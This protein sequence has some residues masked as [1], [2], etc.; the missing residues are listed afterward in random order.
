MDTNWDEIEET[1]EL[2]RSSQ[3]RDERQRTSKSQK[4]CSA[5]AGDLKGFHAKTLLV[6]REP[7]PLALFPSSQLNSFGTGA[8]MQNDDCP[9]PTS[10][11]KKCIS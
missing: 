4:L 7:P 6:E 8:G 1:G 11:W 2:E 10:K 3:A 5:A 9:W